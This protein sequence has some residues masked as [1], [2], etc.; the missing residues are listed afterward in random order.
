M[1]KSTFQSTSQMVKPTFQS[2]NQ[3]VKST[4]LSNSQMVKSMA[5]CQKLHYHNT[6]SSQLSQ[7][8]KST[9]SVKWSNPHS[10]KK[11]ILIAIHIPVSLANGQIHIPRQSQTHIPVQKYTITIHIRQ[12][13]RTVFACLSV[14][15]SKNHYQPLHTSGTTITNLRYHTAA[16]THLKTP[17]LS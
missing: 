7:M 13:N 17:S 6:H 12:L 3:M 11:N 16:S 8:G 9:F 10:S 5:I 15:P 4:F 14:S 2:A 1:V